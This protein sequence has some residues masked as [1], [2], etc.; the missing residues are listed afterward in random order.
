[1]QDDFFLESIYRRF[2]A[3]IDRI[4]SRERSPTPREADVLT[5]V[6]EQIKAENFEHASEL[7]NEEQPSG[8]RATVRASRLQQPDTLL[9]AV[10]DDSSFSLPCWQYALSTV[11]AWKSRSSPHSQRSPIG[12]WPPSAPTPLGRHR[13]S[14]R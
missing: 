1:M 12:K 5:Q 9:A 3:A 11:Q 14:P 2:D 7:L 10:R 6:L 4:D 8:A 13:S